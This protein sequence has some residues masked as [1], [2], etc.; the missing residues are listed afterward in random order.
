MQIPVP[1]FA[2]KARRL[3]VDIGFFRRARLLVNGMPAERKKSAY[4]VRKDS[5]ELV[6]IKLKHNFLDP[7]PTVKIGD[8]LIEL[9]RPL[10][11]YEYLWLGIPIILVF[12]GGGLGGLIG[13]LAVY[14]SARVFRGNRNT[15]AKYGLTGLIS[16]TACG[17]WLIATISVT[18]WLP[19][20]PCLFQTGYVPIDKQQLRGSG[21][22][23][24]VPLDDFSPDT[25]QSLAQYYR[26]KYG[27]TIEVTSPI[28][29]PANTFDEIR[30]Q[31]VAESIIAFLRSDEVFS[32]TISTKI[33]LTDHDIYVKA[34]S[35]R[36]AFSYREPP[37]GV[38]SSARVKHGLIGSG[39]ASP[40]RQAGRFRKMLTKNIG[41]MYYHLPP[42]QYCR[43]VMYGKIGGPQELDFMGEEF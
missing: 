2:F 10:R 43:S 42:S 40:E 38:V 6:L 34:Y 35:W 39:P 3:A 25:A 8:E 23:Y 24:L 28:T 27:M 14:A 4:S 33:A 37:V 26:E 36:Y 16:A 32:N 30:G 17:V 12:A 5:G 9:V 15:F 7:I 22:M 20:L 11:W 21:R 41:I 31:H 29:L 19:L 18:S 1:H 13:V